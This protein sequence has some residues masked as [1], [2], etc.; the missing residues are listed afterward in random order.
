M[1]LAHRQFVGRVVRHLAKLGIR[2]F[3]DI[4]SGLLSHDNTHQLAD[5]IAPDSRVIYVD[6]E[7]VVMAHTE[8]L[9]DEAGDPDRHAVINADL[10]CPDLVWDAVQATGLINQEKP[11][12]VFMFSVLHQ[13]KPDPRGIDIGAQIVARYRRLLPG[14][15]YLGISH[16]TADGVPPALVPKLRELKNL[17]DTWCDGK[18][19]SRSP[20]EI[21]ALL[22][23]FELI[24]P[25]L[26]WTPRWRPREG[27]CSVYADVPSAAATL[28]AVGRKP[29]R[30]RA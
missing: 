13:F 27:R 28:A 24:K 16:L 19:Y 5:A 6:N 21:R 23:D 2:Q 11:V 25:G 8:V 20:A 18:V 30:S 1:V 15:S 29:A 14:G 4:G 9:L 17:C 7:P 22:G 26:V 3:V 12:A 10:R